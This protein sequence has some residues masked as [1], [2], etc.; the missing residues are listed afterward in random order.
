M[1]HKRWLLTI[2]LLVIII[3]I[4]V[5]HNIYSQVTS[6]VLDDMVKNQDVISFEGVTIENETI[7]SDIFSNSKITMISIWGTYCNPCKGELPELALLEENYEASDFQIIGIVKDAEKFEYERVINLAKQLTSDVNTTFPN[8]LND[9]KLQER[10]TNG[11]KHVPTTIFVNSDGQVLKY[12]VGTKKMSE[13]QKI[14][15]ELLAEAK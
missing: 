12:T 11:V 3:S 13:W 7:S 14:V 15:D 9:K 8:L 5:F 10:L 6:P 2:V 4:G 1:K